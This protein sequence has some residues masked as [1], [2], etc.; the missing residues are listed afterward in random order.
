MMNN[1]FN[2]GTLTVSRGTNV[3]WRNN[4]GVIHT[5]TSDTGLWDT[6]NIGGGSSKGVTFSSAGTFNYHCTVHKGMTG[7]IIAQ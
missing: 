1:T 7:T 3:T 5:S 4:D 6:G 2:P